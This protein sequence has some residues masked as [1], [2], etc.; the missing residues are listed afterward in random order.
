MKIFISHS[1]KNADY[2]TAIVTLLRAVGVKAEDIVFTSN[3]AY[4][5]P[6]GENIF[7][8]L[9]SR[10]QEQSY[11]IY[12][13]SDEY[14][15]S[16]ACLN[17][18]GASWVI[19]NKG[20]M[21]FAPGFDL[22]CH[23]FKSGALD[24]REIGFFLYDEDRV[25]EFVESLKADFTILNRQVLLNQAIKIFIND[26]RGLA[27]SLRKNGDKS[28]DKIIVP[29][30]STEQKSPSK[31]TLDAIVNPNLDRYLSDFKDGKLKDSDVML[32]W[33]AIEQGRSQLMTG[34]Q[35]DKEVESIRA[36][37]D[38]NGYPS[39]LSSQYGTALQRL[40]MRKLVSVSQETSSGNPK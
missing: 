17:E 22:D 31:V 19:Q 5:I 8:W 40:T 10:I 12:L 20:A 37:E 16:V 35:E 32:I 18:M 1:S 9:K 7:H 14:Y 3:A 24:P 13:L 34:W 2:G 36:W 33:Y 21:L 28:A 11:V 38:V 39:V 26:V 6:I 29:P 23:E 4:G 25:T 27:I 30:L 15:S